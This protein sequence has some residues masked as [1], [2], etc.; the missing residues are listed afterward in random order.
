MIK[1]GETYEEGERVV[2]RRPA[3]VRLV[4][5][6]IRARSTNARIRSRGN[7]M[8]R[9]VATAGAWSV[10]ADIRSEEPD[11]AR[12]SIKATVREPAR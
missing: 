10:N 7:T 8:T 5:E 9:L 1:Q 4:A 12:W 11:G 6:A 3:L 2:V